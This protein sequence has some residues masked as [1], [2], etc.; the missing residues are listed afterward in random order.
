MSTRHPNP[1]NANPL[2]VLRFHVT[3]AVER[4]EATPITAI[5]HHVMDNTDRKR[6]AGYLH[7]ANV[8]VNRNQGG[9]RKTAS[10]LIKRVIE[11]LM[12]APG[13][14]DYYGNPTERGNHA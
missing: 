7:T 6:V 4:G 5:E 14:T 2:D 12:D 3:G 11:E 8:L 1:R 10:G 9:D 13:M